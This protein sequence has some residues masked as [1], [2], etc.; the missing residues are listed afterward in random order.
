MKKSISLILTLFCLSILIPTIQAQGLISH[1]FNDG[2]MGPFVDCTTKSPN[3]AKVVNNRLRTYWQESSYNASDRMTKGA[4]ACGD[5][6]H[7]GIGYL[8]YKHCWLGFTMN[9]DEAYMG[10]EYTGIG[11]LAQIF[12]F[13]DARGQFSWTAMLDIEDG[14]LT[15]IDRRG[16]GATRVDLTIYENFPRG[17]D[18]DIIIHAVLS[19]NNQG[20]VEI[21]INGN[22][23]YSAYNINIGMGDF[24]DND[25]QT[26]Q[27][28]TEFKIGQYNHSGAHENEIRIVDYDNISWYDGENGYDI[29]N[30]DANSGP[31]TSFTPDPNKTYHIDVPVHDLRL[32]ANG[33]SEDPYTASTSTTGANVGWQFVAASS[34]TWYIRRAAGGSKPGIRTDGTE[35]AD[36]QATSSNGGW[37]RYKI[38]EGSSSGTYFLTLPNGTSDHKRLQVDREGLVKMVPDTY[39][40]TWESFAITE[41]GNSSTGSNVVHITKRNST[42]FAMDGQSGAS[43]RQN[44]Y[45][46]NADVSNGNQQWIEINR[47]NGYYAYQKQGTDYCIDGNNGGANQ[48]NVYLWPCDTENPNQHW[49]KVDAGGGAYKL[50]KRNT[51]YALNGGSGGARE[52]NVNLYDAS[53][54]SQNLH[55]FV[56]PL[57]TSAKSLE[58][59]DGKSIVMYPNPVNTNATITN[60]SNSILTVYDIKGSAVFTKPIANENESIDLSKLTAG[61]YYGK[62]S[63]TGNIVIIKFVKN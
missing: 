16:I 51:N 47:G 29:V 41:T 60:A 42:G 36:M 13:N 62:I 12:G 1:D 31:I 2:D 27:S 30:P 52:Q 7:N 33:E 38:T 37:T 58:T 15:W 45:L 63:T 50:V 14:D 43:E 9:I 56:T 23:E 20:E 46:W 8:T 28:Y 54:S 24:D 35:F 5:P 4:E 55:W 32:A 25:V 49:Q 59:I 57:D 19:D 10:P 3:Y 61:I 34:D 17:R 48:Q 40:G 6:V 26:D 44:I 11:G 21:F 53:S 18:M 39:S 22:L